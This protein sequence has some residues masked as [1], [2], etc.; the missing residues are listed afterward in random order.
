MYFVRNV[1]FWQ[2]IRNIGNSI[3]T[4]IR[5]FRPSVLTIA[6]SSYRSFITMTWF[7]DAVNTL[8]RTSYTWLR[9]A[10]QCQIV[11]TF[12]CKALKSI[13]MCMLGQVNL[14]ESATPNAPLKSGKYFDP[15]N[16]TVAASGPYIPV[17]NFFPY[18]TS[19][20]KPYLQAH[21]N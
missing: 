1:F 8:H 14:S 4:I 3:L 9:L 12:K 13:I 2:R 6:L 5:S 10:F 7:S 20:K 19:E 18:F 11:R 17:G 15:L 21:L 16:I